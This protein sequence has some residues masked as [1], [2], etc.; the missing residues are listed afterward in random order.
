MGWQ[1]KYVW[2]FNMGWQDKYVWSFNMGWQDIT[3]ALTWVGRTLAYFILP[4]C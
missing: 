1:D 3:G 4:T 2:S